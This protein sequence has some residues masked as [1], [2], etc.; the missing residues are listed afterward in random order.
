MKVHLQ[1]G[2]AGNFLGGHSTA[3]RR[4]TDVNG[5]SV[6][7]QFAVGAERYAM[8]VARVLELCQMPEAGVTIL[9]GA[10]PATLGVIN[11]RGTI[12]RVLDT[13]ALLGYPTARQQANDLQQMLAAR[14]QDHVGWLDE[15]RRCVDE[16]TPF[17][18]ATDPTK[19]AFGKWYEQL[20]GDAAKRQDLTGGVSVLERLVDAFDEPH[21]RIHGLAETCLALASKGQQEAARKMIN[22]AWDG[23]LAKMKSLF[24]S[25]LS[26]FVGARRPMLIFVQNDTGR[27]ALAVDRLYGISELQPEAQHRPFDQGPVPLQLRT[28]VASDG[29]LVQVVDLNEVLALDA[30]T[31]AAA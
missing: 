30:P 17:T 20:R 10:T 16:N 28:A 31:K 8:E 24:A 13:R 25:L 12:S 26:E 5:V 27:L 18:K 2:V 14:E 22:D 11:L 29:V 15:L 19:C 6:Y 3:R 23:D 9:P 4:L 7:V 1:D 21:R